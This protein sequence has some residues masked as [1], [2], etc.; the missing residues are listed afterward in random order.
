MFEVGGESTLGRKGSIDCVTENLQ[1][2]IRQRRLTK[3]VGNSSEDCGN[4]CEDCGKRSEDC[5]NFSEDCGNSS[6]DG[7][8]SSENCGNSSDDCGDSEDCGNRSEDYGNS[9][10]DFVPQ[11]RCS[12]WGYN[13][14]P[15]NCNP[16]HRRVDDL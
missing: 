15:K 4:S 12:A 2:P 13:T 14:R 7:G 1:N 10:E 9:S 16:W 6:E 3:E 8:D 5:G 11:R